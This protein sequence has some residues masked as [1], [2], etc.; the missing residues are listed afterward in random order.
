M[1]INMPMLF[2]LT[3]VNLITRA[4]GVSNRGKHS[5]LM[6]KDLRQSRYHKNVLFLIRIQ[7]TKK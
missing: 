4:L 5:E 7:W 2:V 1:I 6:T 3:L